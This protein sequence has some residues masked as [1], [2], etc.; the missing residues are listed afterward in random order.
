ML[1]VVVKH[2]AEEA[3][4]VQQAAEQ[5]VEQI[6]WAPGLQLDGTYD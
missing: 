4:T 1:T 5:S 6:C 2:L 3:V